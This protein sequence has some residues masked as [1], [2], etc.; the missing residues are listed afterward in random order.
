[1]AHLDQEIAE[2]EML[3]AEPILAGDERECVAVNLEYR[4][5]S[6]K[7]VEELLEKLT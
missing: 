3:T 7:R 6:R 5:E 2:C 4:L 1:M